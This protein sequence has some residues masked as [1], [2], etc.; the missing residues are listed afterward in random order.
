MVKRL[1]EKERTEL[2]SSIDSYRKEFEGRLCPLEVL[3]GERAATFISVGGG[4]LGDLAVTAAKRYYG[5]SRGGIRTVAFDRYEGFP[6]QDVS[7]FSEV[8]DMKNGDLLERYI[9]RYVPDPEEHHAICLEVEM[10][11]TERTFRLGMEKGYKVMSTPYGPLICMDRH[12]TKMMLDKLGL[13][14]VEWAY[15]DSDDEVRRIAKDLGLP[16]IVKPVMTSSGHGTTIVKNEV[17]LRDAYIHAKEHARGIGDEVIVEKYLPELKSVGTEITQIVV[18]YFDEDWK[19]VNSYVPP[20]EHKR[21]GATYHE[22]WI[23][24]TITPSAAKSCREAAGKIAN[25]LGGIGIY[26][27]E[28]FVIGDRVYNNEVANRPHDT[29]L[30]TRWMLNMDEGGLQLTSTLGLTVSRSSME[31]SREG[32]YGV[33]HVVLAPETLKGEKKVLGLDLNRINRFQGSLSDFW[34]FGKPSAYAGR[35][36]GLAIG[37]GK[38]LAITRAEAERFAHFAEGCIEYEGIK[39]LK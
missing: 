32:I 13:E 29:G 6:A 5:G 21:P 11:D 19:I 36:M 34:Y 31:I 20:I 12:A 8:F 1:S 26:A 3:R 16:V 37:F 9:R 18:R 22:S 14:R 27:V 17:G 4:E 2:L 23:P 30:I 28:Q 39:C 25:F 24:A 33:A 10:I 7:D 35:R 15:A 38:E